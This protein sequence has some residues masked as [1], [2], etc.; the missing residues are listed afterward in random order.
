MLQASP[1]CSW[2][3]AYSASPPPPAQPLLHL[4]CNQ[5]L[6][7]FLVAVM[8][9]P[10]VKVLLHLVHNLGHHGQFFLASFGQILQLSIMGWLCH[11]IGVMQSL[12]HD[13]VLV[14]MDQDDPLPDAHGHFP[15]SGHAFFSRSFRSKAKGLSELLG[16]RS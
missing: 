8:I 15:Y 2:P 4:G 14:V 3:Q 6:N 13:C 16:M 12:S 11:L 9:G 10:E 1:S 5:G 7:Y